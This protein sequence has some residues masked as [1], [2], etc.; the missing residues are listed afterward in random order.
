[1][2]LKLAVWI[3]LVIPANMVWH[4]VGIVKYKSKPNYILTFIYRFAAVVGFGI[5]LTPHL[6]D[7]VEINYWFPLF[8]FCLST[9]VLIYNPGMNLLKNKFADA[10]PAGFWYLG[11]TSGFFW[12]DF[13]INHPTLY[14]IAYFACIPLFLWSVYAMKNLY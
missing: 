3:L 6:N 10:K 5:L 11:K 12:D 7:V 13:W 8:A 2:I 4:I 9:Y 14:K 1:M